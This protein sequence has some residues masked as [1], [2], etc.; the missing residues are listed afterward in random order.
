MAHPKKPPRQSFLSSDRTLARI[1]RPLRT[2]LHTEAAGGIVLLVAT[3]AALGLANSPLAEGFEKIW[4][5]EL[6]LSVGAFEL[7]EDLRHFVNDALMAVFFFVVG[8]EIKREIV[9][10]ELSDRRKAAL[11]A[12][13]ALGGMVVPAAVYLLFNAGGPG[14]AGWGIPMATDIAFAVGVLALLGSRVPSGLKVFLL[15]LAIV[16]DIGAI[17]VIAVFYSHGFQLGWLI[18]ALVLLAGIVVLRRLKVTWT[19]LYVLVGAGVW[20]ATFESGIHATIAGVALGLLTP[21]R[22]AD[23]RGYKDVYRETGLLEEQP[24]AQSLR[25]VSLQ[26]TEVVSVA[27]RLEYLLHPWTSYAVIPL[28]ALANAG[29]RLSLD[30]LGD[31]MSSPVALGIAA[32]LVLGKIVGISSAAWIA[33]KLNLGRLPAGVSWRVILGGSAVAG[34]G[35]TVSLFI[36]GLAFTESQ[37][38]DEAKIGVLVASVVAGTLGAL[39]LLSSNRQRP[40]EPQE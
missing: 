24:D 28:F 8:L 14:S 27:E 34:I 38:V 18:G 1:A 37:L 25:A 21:A 29:V 36:A 33:V 20:F 4:Q 3:V 2:F 7:T 35:F 23:P 5:T 17:L 22:P 30:T 19:P 9:L 12:I 13:A 40:A 10:G 26:A 15:S 11:P 32:G 16:D 39:L 6:R 31:A